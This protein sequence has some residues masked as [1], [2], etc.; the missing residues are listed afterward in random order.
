MLPVLQADQNFWLC[1]YE[2]DIPLSKLTII[3]EINKPEHEEENKNV[4][5]TTEMYT[6]VKRDQYSIK[7][8]QCAAYGTNIASTTAASSSKLYYQTILPATSSADIEAAPYPAYAASSVKRISDS[9]EDYE[10]VNYT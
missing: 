10:Y 2:T 7:V 9:H 4:S 5:N 6:E 3:K 8:S 1:R